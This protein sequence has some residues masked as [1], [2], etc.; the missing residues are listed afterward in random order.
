MQRRVG[1]SEFHCRFHPP[2]GTPAAAPSRSRGSATLP[3]ESEGMWEECGSRVEEAR[4]RNAASHESLFQAK[5]DWV[6]GSRLVTAN[7][8]VFRIVDEERVVYSCA[9][10]YE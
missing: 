4:A 6:N 3:D 5:Q 9:G 2:D 7:R 10:P 1:S 8:L